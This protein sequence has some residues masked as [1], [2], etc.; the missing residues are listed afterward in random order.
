M[1]AAFGAAVWLLVLG[2]FPGLAQ[3]MLRLPWWVVPTVA[4]VTIAALLAEGLGPS[5]GLPFLVAEPTRRGRWLAVLGLRHWATY[6]PFW[7]S[8]LLGAA[9]VVWFAFKHVPLPA[10]FE[11]LDQ[12][13][14]TLA[15]DFASALVRSHECASSSPQALCLASALV[16]V[17]LS[18]D[19]WWRCKKTVEQP[20]STSAARGQLF[21]LDNLSEDEFER[22]LRDDRPIDRA[23]RDYFGIT[24][25][26]DRISGRLAKDQG[27]HV[28]IGALGSGKTS[29]SKLVERSLVQSPQISFV[30]VSLWEFETS[31]SA[32][33]GVLEA[34]VGKLGE[35]VNV[36]PV[37]GLSESYVR[38]IGCAGTPGSIAA[39]LLAAP[40]PYERL[41]RIEEI[42]AAT[43]RRMVVWLED[44]E[45]FADAGGGSDS[46][47]RGN[48]LRSL[49]S[50]AFGLDQ[51]DRV[52]LV[53]ASATT[54]NAF[55]FEKIAR[56]VEQI[57]FLPAES[58]R[59]MLARFRKWQLE[60]FGQDIDPARPGA[61]EE[62]NAFHGSDLSLLRAHL[63]NRMAIDDYLV[64]AIDTPRR[65]KFA[66]RSVLD[67]WETLH[68]EID[69][70]DLFVMTF[71]RITFPAGYDVL[72]Q[73]HA[74][75]SLWGEGLHA[76][77]TAAN[78]QPAPR[79]SALDE[80]DSPLGHVGRNYTRSVAQF[81]FGSLERQ[82]KPQG[83]SL[84][85]YWSRFLDGTAPEGNDLDQPLLRA[86]RDQNREVLV[87]HLVSRR[88]E[89]VENFS[90][91][92]PDEVAFRLLVPLCQRLV[93]MEPP[94]FWVTEDQFG[95]H[96]P[97]LIHLWLI[98]RA[99]LQHSFRDTI[100]RISNLVTHQLRMA[101]RDSVG[102][103]SIVRD[104]EY[105]YLSEDEESI[106]TRLAGNPE[107]RAS[108]AAP[109]R[110]T[111]WKALVEHYTGHPDQLAQ[112]V[113]LA[114]PFSL[115]QLVWGTPR[116]EML[117]FHEDPF[118]GWPQFA[119]TL[120]DA[121]RSNPVVLAEL[122][123]FLIRDPEQTLGHHER[124][125][126]EYDRELCVH[127]FGSEAE[128]FS[129][130][131]LSI[132]KETRTKG[133]V[134]AVRQA[135]LNAAWARRDEEGWE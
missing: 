104:L 38:A 102:N 84:H 46:Q 133:Y 18:L 41:E 2:L 45:R 26:A 112:A 52:S 88:G 75:L 69:F 85:R 111:L 61:R 53:S 65:L 123:V 29:L 114:P 95:G 117:A 58:V 15:R 50:L 4:L 116:R 92:L 78:G 11:A 5:L 90:H 70:D 80:I 127:L 48:R 33:H 103:L 56:H 8:A 25:M 82:R 62:L 27:S 21:E 79:I 23:E 13:V 7:A 107:T 6:P 14:L 74:Q 105:F 17:I 57:P 64:N 12:S 115:W 32:A 100:A 60:R 68:G 77:G 99:K 40:S 31:A 24:R 63:G 28:V 49:Y 42:L 94:S 54:R 43:D 19:S 72:Y 71:L 39:E 120:L 47:A 51:L 22:W 134:D 130:P 20:S 36:L 76:N 66:L 35:E 122:A 128:V 121:A 135:V 119:S 67:L 98:W 34:I 37:R 93:K 89:M 132:P 91:L 10:V 3:W 110:E 87:A 96:A 113:S 81:V 131:W 129:L 1:T 59:G 101:L 108:V 73:N 55:D 9:V 124:D 86:I 126:F 16:F 106:P 125:I 44:A 118:P 30:R 83:L 97:G 109:L